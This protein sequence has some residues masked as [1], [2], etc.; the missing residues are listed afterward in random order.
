[1]VFVTRPQPDTR[2]IVEPQSSPFWLF[3][4]HFQSFTSPE[5]FDPFVIHN[6]AVLSQH[7]SDASVSIPA[8]LRGQPH[9]LPHQPGFIIGNM[10][11]TSLCRTRL[12]QHAASPSFRDY[13]MSQ[14]VTHV[15]H[16]PAAFG[17]RQKFP[18]AASF[19]IALSNSASASS[20]LSRTF[21]R[22]SSFRRFA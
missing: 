1:M 21:S 5:S 9:H 4:R 16:S 22:S 15:I 19:R 12:S 6:P 11:N 20:F 10:R 8:I 3:R 2:T 13:I 18:E 17:W 14:R 7:R